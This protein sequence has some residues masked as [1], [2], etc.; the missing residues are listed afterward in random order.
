MAARAWALLRA[1]RGG[2]GAAGPGS[3]ALEGLWGA[4]GWGERHRQVQGAVGWDIEA[5]AGPG[6][7]VRN[8]GHLGRCGAG[9]WE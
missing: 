2:A 8:K 4:M 3:G 9:G 1:G 6:S 5:L 7:V